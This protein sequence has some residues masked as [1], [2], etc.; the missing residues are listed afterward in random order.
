MTLCVFAAF[1]ADMAWICL[2]VPRSTGQGLDVKC[3][4]AAKQ[5]LTGQTDLPCCIS[6]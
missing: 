3:M 1:M 6:R 4:P 5:Q 2:K